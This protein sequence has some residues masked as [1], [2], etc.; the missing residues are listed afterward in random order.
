MNDFDKKYPMVPNCQLSQ[1]LVSSSSGPSKSQHCSSLLRVNGLFDPSNSDARRL[2]TDT[3]K[4][5]LHALVRL[6]ET[7]NGIKKAKELKKFIEHRLETNF[8][9]EVDEPVVDL[10]FDL[11]HGDIDFN[12]DAVLHLKHIGS[13]KQVARLERQ[14]MDYESTAVTL[15]QQIH[16]VVT[17]LTENGC[18]VA[19]GSRNHIDSTV[20]FLHTREIGVTSMLTDSR[21]YRGFATAP[22]ALTAR[23]RL[24]NN[25]HM[26]YTIS[27]HMTNPAYCC[28]FDRTGKFLITGADDYLVKIWDV[29]AGHLVRTCRGHMSYISFIVVSPDNSIFASSCTNGSVRIWR[30]RDGLCLRVFQLNS[31]VHWMQ[32]DPASCSL[33]TGSEN[34]ICNIWDLSRV[35]PPDCT[36]VPL[37]DKVLMRKHSHLKTDNGS[38]CIGAVVSQG[39]DFEVTEV[40]EN[41]MYR[42]FTGLFE[43]SKDVDSSAVDVFSASAAPIAPPTVPASK[44]VL[45]LP[46]V[47]ELVPGINAQNQASK[48][49]CLDIASVGNV[50]VTGCDDGVARLWKFGNLDE[51]E[52]SI[53]TDGNVHNKYPLRS[54]KR[55][56]ESRLMKVKESCGNA[57]KPIWER[58]VK[59]L[60][61]RLEGHA[62]PITDI[63][64]NSLGDR[65]LTGSE[66][67]GVRIWSLAKDY[68]DSVQLVLDLTEEDEQQQLMMG[69]GRGM[70]RGSNNRSK[71]VVH[72]VCWTCN[73]LRV[74]TLQSVPMSNGN[75]SSSNNNESLIP[76]RL[77]VWDAITGDLLR[78]IR[79][80]SGFPTKCLARH[81]YNPHLV[82]TGGDDGMV[83]VWNIDTEENLS[84]T[85]VQIVLEEQTKPLHVTDLSIS[86][87]GH[88]IAATDSHGQLTVI[89]LDN[90]LRFAHVLKEQYYSTDYAD[91]MVDDQ[92][93]A[94]DVGTQLPADRAPLGPLCTVLGI[95]HANQ[96]HIVCHPQPCDDIEVDGLIEQVIQDRQRLPQEMER[97]FSI[98]AKNKNSNRVS[99]KY[100]ARMGGSLT[101]LPNSSPARNLGGDVSSQVN[102][103]NNNNNNSVRYIEFDE[104][105]SSDDSD[106]HSGR[107]MNQSSRGRRSQRNS[108]SN[109]HTLRD[110]AR[111]MN[112]SNSLRRSSR[113][114]QHFSS[115]DDQFV[116][117]EE[118]MYGNS[119]TARLPTR[120]ERAA[121]RAAARESSRAN[122]QSSTYIHNLESDGSEFASGDEE[123]DDDVNSDLVNSDDE[124]RKP[125][126]RSGRPPKPSRRSRLDTDDEELEISDGSENRASSRRSRPLTEEFASRRVQRGESTGRVRGRRRRTPE[127]SE[128]MG[129]ELDRSWLQQDAPSEYVYS[130]QV[131]DIVVYFPQGHKEQL[132]HFTES[133][134]P[135]WVSFGQRLPFYECMVQDI[136]YEFPT[137]Q[138]FRICKSAVAKITLVV[139]RIPSRTTLTTHGS[140]V[141]SLMELRS[142]RHSSSKA[143]SF[144]VKLRNSG[145]ADFVI[146]ASIFHRSIRLSWHQGVEILC[147]FSEVDEN[148]E[149]VLKDYLGKVVRLCNSDSE[150]PH[151]PWEALEVVWDSADGNAE[152]NAPP[153]TQ[154]ISPWDAVPRHSPTPCVLPKVDKELCIRIE[155]A[156]A[157]LMNEKGDRYSPFEY[158]V[159]SV[160]FPHYY[161]LIAVPSYVDLIRRRLKSDYYRQV[162]YIIFIMF[163]CLIFHVATLQIVSLEWDINLLYQNCEAF[164]QQGSDIV[165]AARELRDDLLSIVHASQGSSSTTASVGAG[166]SSS[167]LREESS[168]RASRKSQ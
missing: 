162:S 41:V 42:P 126:R 69:G 51:D 24:T 25:F 33:A 147:K 55:P 34:G 150:W 22:S 29:H 132:T 80:I 10:T 143:F 135:P 30:L 21:G 18:R 102:R 85:K 141:V 131:G 114:R 94:I 156:I 52:L 40:M 104:L 97:M 148:G 134:S 75:G 151:S 36:A 164:N 15:K 16:D 9:D 68:M 1:L 78:I 166:Y 59:H 87:D 48:V 115:Y 158:E 72:N 103:N 8:A 130:P 90:P 19:S 45:T 2:F 112:D 46:H 3:S 139:L 73:D 37:L 157:D 167:M 128:L 91:V 140:Y 11:T 122:R 39:D 119:T 152:S 159:D 26:L 133:S 20:R 7:A 54:P 56:L 125:R 127:G 113:N 44:D 109:V 153:E 76:T 67:G 49:W 149:N 144:E 86:P 62:H 136:A 95:V 145:L 38:R 120:A 93:Y 64:F 146:P 5:L 70:R 123:D 71:M 35:L 82:V 168:G 108:G 142:T 105:T 61:L 77:K 23:N 138:E 118:A 81:P 117:E 98:F 116:D 28:V 96:P 84:Q 17:K 65:V 58:F 89:G 60:L 14:I 124:D 129:L 137:E 66:K 50:V 160:I 92:G 32:F 106:D 12:N 165:N 27:G 43:W 154:R 110:L 63:H 31:T 101:R 6:H 155:A 161:S 99:K 88:T 47:N 79:T 100:S 13:T 74:V 111:N 163:C 57:D 53:S 121:A 83:S 4:Q 107:R